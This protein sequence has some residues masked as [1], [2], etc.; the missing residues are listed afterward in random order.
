MGGAGVIT[1]A[2]ARSK[3]WTLQTI[4]SV[5]TLVR[6]ALGTILL[7]A[8]ISKGLQAFSQPTVEAQGF[9][10]SQW[11]LVGLVEFEFVL[12]TLLVLGLFPRATWYVALGTFRC[13]H[14][15]DARTGRDCCNRPSLGLAFWEGLCQTT[16]IHVP[17][18]RG[19][20]GRPVNNARSVQCRSEFRSKYR[21]E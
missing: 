9:L 5:P 8:S 21:K 10:D 7:F 14:Y 13:S 4:V 6:I 20:G 11:F 19:I 15:G 17:L 2:L 18:Y 16:N 12:G 3:A 1:A